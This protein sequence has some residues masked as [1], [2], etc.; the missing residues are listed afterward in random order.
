[1]ATLTAAQNPVG[2]G[3]VNIVPLSGGGGGSPSGPAGGVLSGTFPN[4]GFASIAPV[5]FSAAQLQACLNSTAGA[6][7]CNV[8]A[9]PGSGKLYSGIAYT[10]ITGAGSPGVDYTDSMLT[11]VMC[12]I[13]VV[14]VCDNLNP[15]VV[16]GSSPFFASSSTVQWPYTDERP[17]ANSPVNQPI[18][19]GVFGIPSGQVITVIPHSG[20]AGLLY[21]TATQFTITANDPNAMSQT[22]ATCSPATVLGG[23]VLTITCTGAG[24][25]QG[26]QYYGPG[27]GADTAI[28]TTIT[29]GTGDGNLTVDITAI[30]SY[31]LGTISATV[32]P[33]YKICS[34]T[35]GCAN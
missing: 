31:G 23:V 24:L 15:A 12:L 20:S 13:P 9:A 7:A 4:P 30:Q 11:T 5:T 26:N 2:G 16:I 27:S 3:G 35:L 34:V 18:V 8:A 33:S 14:N 6:G 28:T 10:V 19:L 25:T 29:S 21:T 1:M 32:Y 17:I 22:L